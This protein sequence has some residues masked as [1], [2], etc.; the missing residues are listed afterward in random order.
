MDIIVC[1]KRVPDAASRIAIDT[2]GFDIRRDIP[3]IIN[4]F[5]E[6]ALHAALAIKERFGGSVTLIHAGA[7]D[8]EEM[9]RKGIALGAD[10]AV[11]IKDP[12]INHA[13]GMTIARAISFVIRPMP[14]DI[15]LAGRRASD[16]DAGITGPAIAAFLDIPV[17]PSIKKL[18]IDPA[19]MLASALADGGA[20]SVECRLPALFTADRGLCEPRYPTLAGIMGSKKTSIRYLDL[21]AVGV[22]AAVLSASPIQRAGIHLPLTTRKGVILQEELPEQVKAA[23]RFLR[24]ETEGV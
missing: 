6:I 20:C 11:Y 8:G 14:F 4:P 9:L 3:W 23:A 22:D 1:L 17:V 10:R 5:D 19:T 15:I 13:D 21:K 18:D 24:A 16:T 12:A 7:E 2:T